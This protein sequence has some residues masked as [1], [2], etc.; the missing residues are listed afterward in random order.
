MAE[1]PLRD[2]ITITLTADEFDLLLL[3]MGQATGAAM[4]AGHRSLGYRFLRLA[5]RINEG[6]PR[7]RPYEIPPGIDED[8]EM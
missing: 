3:M 8:E 2:S 1:D 7:W 6:N 5:N 4:G